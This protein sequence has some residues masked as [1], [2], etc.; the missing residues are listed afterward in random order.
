MLEVRLF[1][2][3]IWSFTFFSSRDIILAL[4]FEDLIFWYN[5]KNVYPLLA[6]PQTLVHCGC[7]HI[8]QGMFLGWPVKF[9]AKSY[10]DIK[11]YKIL[12]GRSKE[13]ILRR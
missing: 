3:I 5:N 1:T 10:C 9:L 13:N 8:T 4:L 7:A 12:L 2:C 11:L 6:S